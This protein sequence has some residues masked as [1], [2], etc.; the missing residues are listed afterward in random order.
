MA[1]E[2]VLIG[3]GVSSMVG[4]TLIFWV[5]SGTSVVTFEVPSLSIGIGVSSMRVEPPVDP[6]FIPSVDIVDWI[7]P[8]PVDNQ[9]AVLEVSVEGIGFGVSPV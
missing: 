9:D 8:V 2:D 7:I 5:V 3:F 1:V 4:F 6:S